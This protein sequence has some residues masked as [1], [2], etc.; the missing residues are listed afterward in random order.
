MFSIYMWIFQNYFS[1]IKQLSSS[2]YKRRSIFFCL[3][4]QNFKIIYSNYVY[5][6]S[7]LGVSKAI[8]PIIKVHY[9][10]KNI[11]LE[12]YLNSNLLF[13]EFVSISSLQNSKSMRFVLA[14]FVS[15][16]Q[17]QYNFLSYSSLSEVTLMNM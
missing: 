5:K 15:F 6:L 3:F 16:L 12:S 4:V 1:K 9:L 13:S 7:F 14:H 17:F 10:F 2:F 11:F 8:N